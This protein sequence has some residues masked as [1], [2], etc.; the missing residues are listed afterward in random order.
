MTIAAEFAKRVLATRS[1]NEEPL[2]TLRVSLFVSAIIACRRAVA[3]S[4]RLTR[5]ATP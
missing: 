4:A 2:L 5:G 3:E 1:S